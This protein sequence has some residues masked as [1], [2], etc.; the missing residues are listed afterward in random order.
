MQLVL[1]TVAMRYTT[2]IL[3]KRLTCK[4]QDDR[5]LVAERIIAVSIYYV[6]NSSILSVPQLVMNISYINS[7]IIYPINVTLMTLVQLTSYNDLGL[8][9]L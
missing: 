1:N 9:Y 6:N 2:A 5:K 8:S 4:T 7:V 3:Q